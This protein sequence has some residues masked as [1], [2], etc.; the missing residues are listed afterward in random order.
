[1][2]ERFAFLPRFKTWARPD[3]CFRAKLAGGGIDRFSWW[4]PL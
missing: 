3:E 2:P 4:N 1:L